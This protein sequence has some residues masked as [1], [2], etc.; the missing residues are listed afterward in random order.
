MQMTKTWSAVWWRGG[1]NIHWLSEVPLHALWAPALKH[2]HVR[3]RTHTHTHIQTAGGIMWWVHQSDVPAQLPPAAAIQLHDPRPLAPLNPPPTRRPALA[4]QPHRTPR[5]LPLHLT[6][7]SQLSII[8][9][10]VALRGQPGR[11]EGE[12]WRWRWRDGGR[13]G[14]GEPGG[15]ESWLL[16]T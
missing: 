3:T 2:K 1:I 8:D 11:Q 10:W 12:R 4:V 5:K 13:G 16:L 14:G 6:C 15:E 9:E 7:P